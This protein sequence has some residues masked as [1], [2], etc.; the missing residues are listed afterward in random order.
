M[1]GSAWSFC[2]KRNPH[3]VGRIDSSWIPRSA[4]SFCSKRS[5]HSVGGIDSSWIPRSARSF[6]SK[7]SQFSIHTSTNSYKTSSPMTRPSFQISSCS[8]ATESP[9]TLRSPY[10]QKG[11]FFVMVSHITADYAL[12]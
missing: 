11:A 8:C 7:R 10:P 5:P 6:C 3:P 12:L 4:W 9:G 2:S 1:H